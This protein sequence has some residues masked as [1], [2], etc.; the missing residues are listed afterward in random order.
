V[1]ALG[2]LTGFGELIG[3]YRDEPIRAVAHL[4]GAAYLLINAL[5]AVGAFAVIRAF[6]WS[7]GLAA[8]APDAAVSTLQVLVAG[9]AAAACS[10]APSSRPASATT[11][12]ASA[13]AP[14]SM[15]CCAQSTERSIASAQSRG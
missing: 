14:C 12:S 2:A 11:T 4:S 1:F 8:D 5:A 10:A 13:P 6:D 7:F 3:R 15:C 9:L